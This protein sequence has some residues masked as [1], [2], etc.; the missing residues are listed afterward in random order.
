MNYSFDFSQKRHIDPGLVR[1]FLKDAENDSHRKSYGNVF[2]ILYAII[3]AMLIYICTDGGGLLPSVLICVAP[4]MCVFTFLYS[5]IYAKIMPV[6]LPLVFYTIRLTLSGFN[7]DFYTITTTLFV[8]CLCILSAAI[9]TKAVLSGH[10]KSTVL[11]ELSVVYGLI[12]MS[13]IA[14]VFI[15]VRGS[16]GINM[17]VEYIDQY[18]ELLLRQ[19][20]DASII[21]ANY[22]MFSAFG[23]T[24]QFPT[25]EAFTDTVTTYVMTLLEAIKTCLPGI[26]ALTCM[27]FGFF[28]VAVF[29]VV[30]RIFR[31]NVFVS[32]MDN[33]WTYRPGII[34]ANVYDLL[35]IAVVVGM[36][37]P[38]PKTLSAAL[39]NMLLIL[40]P[41]MCLSGIKGIYEFLLKKIHSKIVALLIAAL[42]V[43]A[44]S[45]FTGA[46]VF[47]I[48]ASA[49]IF[50]I[51]AKNREEKER[52]PE[53]Y[54]ADRELFIKLYGNENN[55][56]KE[57][58]K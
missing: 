15:S 16:F 54:I 11:V 9:M 55:N 21:D 10:T 47:F 2:H 13:Q 52:F 23:M 17:L 5:P 45:M 43:F 25:K 36:F 22:E 19:S 56:D 44:I 24:E 40:T 27:F 12:L 39:V 57:T 41:I 50:F 28:S 42:I 51:S 49:G 32:I 30:A 26:F 7:E 29:S 58:D 35:F 4:A 8:Y 6:A 33:S 46:F 37:V 34:T 20:T 31:I 14:F 53:K 1:N 38:Y 3:C 18:F 48:L